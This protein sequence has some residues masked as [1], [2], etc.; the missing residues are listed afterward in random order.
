[1]NEE[2][3]KKIQRE[4]E[5]V[6]FMEDS[7]S[8]LP[9]LE[10]EP[11]SR[12]AFDLL[13]EAS[14]F[15]ILRSHERTLR[16]LD[17]TYQTVIQEKSHQVDI[18][19]STVKQ[20][21]EQIRIFNLASESISQDK[22]RQIAHLAAKLEETE[23]RLQEISSDKDNLPEKAQERAESSMQRNTWIPQKF[24]QTQ[25]EGSFFSLWI[26]NNL[27]EPLIALFQKDEKRQSSE[28]TAANT[29]HSKAAQDSSAIVLADGTQ[30]HQVAFEISGINPTGFPRF[31]ATDFFSLRDKV[32]SQLPLNQE[33]ETNANELIEAA[34][35]LS[36]LENETD[37]EERTKIFLS[38]SRLQESDVK[39]IIK[40]IQLI[41]SLENQAYGR[42][43]ADLSRLRK[44]K[45]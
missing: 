3:Y 33:N 36:R 22:D 37:T 16:T 41:S 28:N 35:I 17:K 7:Q 13:D 24:A 9:P 43:I 6:N 31:A 15:E 42:C 8:G 32:Y 29:I 23:K 19:Q 38:Y 39:K 34:Q 20:A 5:K 40:A 21:E 30:A 2:L 14:K 45:S 25:S 4:L 44:M 10:N 11:F 18:L 27:I 12:E 1:M 26:K